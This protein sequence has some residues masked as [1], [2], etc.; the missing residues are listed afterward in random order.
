MAASAA[1]SGKVNRNMLAKKI[2]GCFTDAIQRL[3]EFFFGC[4]AFIIQLIA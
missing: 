4:W 2:N 1:N 3:F